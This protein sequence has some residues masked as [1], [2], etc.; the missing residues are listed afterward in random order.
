MPETTHEILNCGIE[1][2]VLPLP[3]RHVVSF[4]IRVLAGA[5]DD[6]PQRLGISRLVT[7]TI[8]K[9]TQKR[10]GRE[11]FD[12]FD[13][14]G[15]RV[16][17]GTGVETATY[18]CTVLPEHFEKAMALHA[19]MLASPTFPD[20][21]SQVNVQL[22]QQEL[23]ALEDDAHGLTEKLLNRHAYGSVLGRSPLGEKETLTGI[24]RDHLVELWKQFY[25]GG[26]ILLAVA[27]AVDPQSVREVVEREFGGLG[28]AEQAGRAHAAIEFSP[29]TRHHMKE[30]KQEQ[31]GICWPGVDVTHDDYPTQ[32]LIIGVLSGG[33][34]G[35]L[36]TEVREKQGLVY[37]VGA[38]QESPRGGG[39]L[40][41]GASTT[42]E[43]C[44]KT[45][46]TLLREVDRLAEDLEEDELERAKTGIV[47]GTETR[48]DATRSRC[49]EL[50]SDLFHYGRPRSREE[51]IARIMAVGLD[52][53]RRYLHEH[54]R[55]QLCVLTLGPKALA[56]P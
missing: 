11:L 1:L 5:A 32:S 23:I 22:A 14:I 26:R 27:G 45:Y 33:M 50:A 2:A 39:M 12:A 7:E 4:Q 10:S 42:P 8:D 56:N 17:S 15:A 44:D 18:S 6:P 13:A 47:A 30:L 46:N 43:R 48:G 9:G 20:D 3:E 36:F 19:E 52:D 24:T 41:L 29:G 54:P 21:A 51:K 38:W 25:H 34:S 40:F 55:D 28:S 35:R 16:S 31:I 49:A 53:V 37:W